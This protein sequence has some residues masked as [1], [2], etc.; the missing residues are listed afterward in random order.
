MRE[1]NESR[2]TPSSL[3]CPTGRM[4]KIGRSNFGQRDNSV[5]FGIG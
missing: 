4:G 2:M 3:V 5:H 1:I